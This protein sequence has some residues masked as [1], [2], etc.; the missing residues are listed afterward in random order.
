MRKGEYI[1]DRTQMNVFD[2]MRSSA[3]HNRGRTLGPLQVREVLGTLDNLLAEVN[4][5][6]EENAML[7][8][9]IQNYEEKNE[10]I[11]SPEGEASPSVDAQTV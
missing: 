7:E 9:I 4:R 11:E 3:T 5:L 8:Q 1:K 10:S 6:A 2:Y